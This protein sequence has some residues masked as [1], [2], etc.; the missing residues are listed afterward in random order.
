MTGPQTTAQVTAAET[1]EGAYIDDRIPK[2]MSEVHERGSH[3]LLLIGDSIT[4]YQLADSMCFAERAGLM[5]R[6]FAEVPN[7][8][9]KYN[10]MLVWMVCLYTLTIAM[11]I[12]I[13][14]SFEW[15]TI[16]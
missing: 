10:A 9:N 5:T 16:C 1:R 11:L 14:P 2:D 7:A 4:R 8:R 3:P 15:F 6:K 12:L 13:G